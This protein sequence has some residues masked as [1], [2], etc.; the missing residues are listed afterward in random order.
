MCGCSLEGNLGT[1]VSW[2]GAASVEGLFSAAA[3]FTALAGLFRFVWEYRRRDCARLVEF[4]FCGHLVMGNVLF[5]YQLVSE[6]CWR[7]KV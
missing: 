2:V 1:E 3:R 6:E 7:G 4:W 5:V